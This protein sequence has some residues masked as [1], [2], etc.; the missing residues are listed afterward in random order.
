MKAIFVIFF[1]IS[2]IFLI[3]LETFFLKFLTV[4]MKSQEGATCSCNLLILWVRN[5]K[6]HPKR[7]TSYH[8][9]N[10]QAL[11]SHLTL[12]NSPLK[13]HHILTVLS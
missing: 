1:H 6:C 3:G 12:L 5:L 2:L 8:S 7:T 10:L 9:K 13:R 11:S 4:Q